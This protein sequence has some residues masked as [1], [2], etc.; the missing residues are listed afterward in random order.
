MKR[1]LANPALFWRIAF[2]VTLVVV[3]ILSLWPADQVPS[4]TGW[5]KG[6]HVLAFIVLSIMGRLGF[7]SLPPALLGFYLLSYGALIEV[8]QAMTPDRYAEWADL[9]ADAIGIVAG[10]LLIGWWR[11]RSR[12][13]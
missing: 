7:T 1:L 12:S 2:I 6:N 4:G 9:G 13:C 3:A 10:V 11:R 5:D 8:L